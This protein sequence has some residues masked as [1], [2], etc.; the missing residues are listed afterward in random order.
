[1]RDPV[2]PGGKIGI[3]YNYLV[4]GTQKDISQFI[5]IDSKKFLELRSLAVKPLCSS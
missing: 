5:P 4:S 3:G 1:L 2:R